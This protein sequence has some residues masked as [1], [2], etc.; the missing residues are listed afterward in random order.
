MKKII[1]SLAAT[2]LTAATVYCGPGH[3]IVSKETHGP[4]TTYACDDGKTF[5]HPFNGLMG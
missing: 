1:R 5:D 2:I 3:S 4:I